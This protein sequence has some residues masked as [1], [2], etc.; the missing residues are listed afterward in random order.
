MA[1]LIRVRLSDDAHWRLKIQAAKEKTT[2]QE[3][4]SSL[5]KKWL[6]ERGI[7]VE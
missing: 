2:I 6:K 7:E 3:I 1:K 5:I 4:V